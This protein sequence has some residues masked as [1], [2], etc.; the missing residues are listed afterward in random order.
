MSKRLKNKDKRELEKK[1]LANT[2][3]E[4][5][6]EYNK[7]LEKLKK[8]ISDKNIKNRDYI[9]LYSII[10]LLR[11]SSKKLNTLKETCAR[12]MEQLIYEECGQ[13]INI[14]IC[15]FD[16]S[17]KTLGIG[18]KTNPLIESEQY[19]SIVFSK[20]NNELCINRT[21]L[22]ATSNAIILRTTGNIISNLYDEL[23]KYSGYKDINSSNI[24]I[25]GSTFSCDIGKDK[26]TVE[27]NISD[28]NLQI[29]SQTDISQNNVS[30]NSSILANVIKGHEDE[31]LKRA[32]VKIGD[33]PKY[34]R[35]ALKEIRKKQLTIKKKNKVLTLKSDK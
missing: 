27:G 1:L 2:S 16:S 9:S 8:L 12:S 32:Y 14:I 15:E 26:V 19:K 35:K 33:C 11:S 20:E 25:P 22:D 7:I 3:T 29:I 5:E 23:A 18:I 4:N 13:Y 24:K 34:L 30:S 31:L 10:K 21:E 28:I 17:S 6:S